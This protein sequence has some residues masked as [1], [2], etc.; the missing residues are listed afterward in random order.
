[1]NLA[2]FFWQML[3]NPNIVYLLLIAGL[4][5]VALAFTTPGAGLP[6]AGALVFLSLAV[7]GLMR[8]PVNFFGLA[9]VVLSVVLYAIEIK[10]PSHGAF[11]ITGMIT[12][13]AGSLF[14]FNADESA[15]RVS[16]LLVAVTVLGTAGFFTFAL[17]KALELRRRPPVHNPD[18]VVGRVGEARTDILKEGTVQVG[19]ELWSAQAD[20]MIPAGA[21]VQI[22]K[23]S[24]LTLKVTRESAKPGA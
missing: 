22:V 24:G 21:R 20:E 12:L 18:S 15:T 4:W 23:R 3:T 6:E 1:M 16:L 19:N 5:M 11:L 8:L 17:V 13:A 9:L 7:L 2:E 14:L 10:W